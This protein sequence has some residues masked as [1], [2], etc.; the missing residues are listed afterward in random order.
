MVTG[1]FRSSKAMLS[2]LQSN[3]TDFIGLARPM[4]LDTQLPNKLMASDDHAISLP[5]LT[6]GV[7][8]IDRMAMLDITWYEAQLARIA[9]QQQPKANLGTWPVFFKTIYGAGIYAF[10]KLRA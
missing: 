10:R 5:N 6:T 7:K 8:A 4:S 3:A 2:A 1:G 9:K